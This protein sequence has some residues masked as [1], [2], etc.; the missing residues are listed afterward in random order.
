MIIHPKTIPI[1][2]KNGKLGNKYA[3]VNPNATKAEIGIKAKPT[4]VITSGV[5]L[6]PKPKSVTLKTVAVIPTMQVTKPKQTS[7]YFQHLVK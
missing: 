6:I 5:T 1:H 2:I 3:N 4:K 7:F